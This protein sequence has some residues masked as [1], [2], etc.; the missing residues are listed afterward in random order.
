M[1]TTSFRN[2]CSSIS[3]LKY[4]QQWSSARWNSL[5]Y[6]K[7]VHFV[8][9]SRFRPIDFCSLILSFHIL[10][11]DENSKPLEIEDEINITLIINSCGTYKNYTLFN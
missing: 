10:K 7:L 9:N 2:C 6:F 4:C 5:I 11:Y 1:K 3:F 8:N